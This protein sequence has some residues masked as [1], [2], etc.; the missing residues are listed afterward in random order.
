MKKAGNIFLTMFVLVGFILSQ[1]NGKNNVISNILI[2]C[3][4]IT[5]YSMFF[6]LSLGFYWI[7]P[8][9]FIR[10]EA[11]NPGQLFDAFGHWPY[12]Y[13]V[14]IYSFFASFFICVIVLVAVRMILNLD[15]HMT[16]L[17]YNMFFLTTA[18]FS[19][20]YFMYHISVKNVSTKVVK[21]RVRLYLA[22]A[23]TIT[24]GLFGLSL[25][26]IFTPLITYLGMGFAWLSFFMDKIDSEG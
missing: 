16:N 10:K 4:V 14:F 2:G 7:K 18:V 6:I 17:F 26:E 11:E 13:G 8:P 21:A 3:L 20:L 15:L 12:L 25:K 22:I 24:A 9:K 19:V 1:M 5:L 23:T